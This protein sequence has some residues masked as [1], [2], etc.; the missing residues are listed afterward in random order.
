M[1]FTVIEITKKGQAQIIQHLNRQSKSLDA[2]NNRLN[3]NWTLVY[4]L[5]RAQERIVSERDLR[6]QEKGTTEFVQK[7]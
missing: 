5:M 2:S 4:S 6:A 1:G 7:K 3:A